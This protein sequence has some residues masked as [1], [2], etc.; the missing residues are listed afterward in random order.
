M[1][2]RVQDVSG[3]WGAEHIARMMHLGV[4]QGDG[5]GMFRPDET[6]TRAHGAA[7]MWR[8]YEQGMQQ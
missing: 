6:A 7:I 4:V 5:Q 3:T 2:A 1:L 8:W